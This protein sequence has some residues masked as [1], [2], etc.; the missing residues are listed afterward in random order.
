MNDAQLTVT[1]DA[2]QGYGFKTSLA[3][4]VHWMLS[5]DFLQGYIIDREK[6]KQEYPNHDGDQCIDAIFE[7]LRRDAYKY[8]AEGKVDGQLKLVIVVNDGDDEEHLRKT[9]ETDDDQFR[10]AAHIFMTPGVWPTHE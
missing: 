7:L 8:I 1:E 5:A 6:V 4:R 10:Q 9:F 3:R 2:G